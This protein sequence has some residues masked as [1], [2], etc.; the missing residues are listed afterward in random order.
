MRR[1]DYAAPTE[2]FEACALLADRGDDA[3]ALAG[4]TDLIVQ[5]RERDRRV[6]L[7]VSLRNLDGFKGIAQNV[8]GSLIIGAMATGDEVNHSP[9]VQSQASL[10][11]RV[12]SCSVQFRFATAARWAAMLAMRRRAPTPRR[13]WSPPMP[14]PALWVPKARATFWLVIS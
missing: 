1:F 10:S 4:G 7:V 8:D 5:M 2:V 12:R 6:P 3:R 9:L 11:A 14:L 13:L